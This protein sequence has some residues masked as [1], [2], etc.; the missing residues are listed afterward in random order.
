MAR[1]P[2]YGSV[3]FPSNVASSW[4][5][6]TTGRWILDPYYGWT[7]IDDAP[8]GWAPFHYGRWVYVDRFWGWAPG[9]IVARPYY[10]PALVAFFSAG[11]ISIGVSLGEIRCSAGRARLGRAVSPVVGSAR[12]HGWRGGSAGA[13]RAS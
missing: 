5:P 7:W 9:P 10:A 11:P 6:Y 8:W 12:L 4:A 1:V 3:W 2:R 13:G